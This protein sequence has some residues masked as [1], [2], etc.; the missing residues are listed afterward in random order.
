[1]N[2]SL[3]IREISRLTGVNTVTLRAWERRYGLLKPL[4]THKGH[5]LYGYE[6]VELVNKI[7]SWLVRGLAISKVSELLKTGETDINFLENNGESENIWQS[8]FQALL[9]IVADLNI[10]K[11]ESFIGE[12]FSVYPPDVIADCLVSPMLDHLQKNSFGD[13]V[14]RSIF[15]QRLCEYL[16]MLIQ[17]QRN[18]SKGRRVA[19]VQVSKD[20]NPLLNVLL[21]YGLTVNHYRCENV[22]L[23]DVN[24]SVFLQKN[25]HLDAIIVYNDSTSS[26]TE[27][28][29]LLSQ[30]LQKISIPI[31]IAGKLNEA[32]K[33]GEVGFSENLFIVDG[34][35]QKAVVGKL[36]EIFPVNENEDVLLTVKETGKN[37]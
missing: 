6:D 35:G 4:R 36:N 31:L 13:G 24:E 16:H 33:Q 11:L 1:M 20:I 22:G 29:K 3:P 7:Q 18:Q 25:L 14:K 30:L 32:L 27:F 12:M 5:R 21:H 2:D 9:T 8:N 15:T 28:K 10:G 26:I 17:R 23:I 37:V 34:Y 19:I